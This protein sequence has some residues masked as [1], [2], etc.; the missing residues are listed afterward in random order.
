MKHPF[1]IIDEVLAG[2]TAYSAEEIKDAAVKTYRDQPAHRCYW[3]NRFF[4]AIKF[5]LPAKKKRES[6][7]LAVENGHDGYWEWR[8][9]SGYDMVRLL[10]EVGIIE[11]VPVSLDE[12]LA[13][14]YVSGDP[15]VMRQIEEKY[16]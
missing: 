15:T 14:Q 10:R 8:T 5:D 7:E 2:S 16:F 1:E 12:V 4:L 3:N 11:G 13:H 6:A 9:H